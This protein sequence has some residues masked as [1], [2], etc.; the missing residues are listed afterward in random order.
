MICLDVLMKPLEEVLGKDEHN[1]LNLN[2]NDDSRSIY[3]IYNKVTI[4]F[5]MWV[6]SLKYTYNKKRFMITP[7]SHVFHSPCMEKWME[8]K[9]ECPYCRRPIPPLE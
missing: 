1:N 9:N 3:Y 8:L 5:K 7:C 6:E 4:K 2:R